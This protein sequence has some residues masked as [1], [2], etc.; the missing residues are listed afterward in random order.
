[1]KR[2]IVADEYMV[3]PMDD[4][5]YAIFRKQEDKK[6][7][8][9]RFVEGKGRLVWRYASTFGHA[10]LIIFEEMEREHHRTCDDQTITDVKAV[11]GVWERIEKRIME[12]E[13]VES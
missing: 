6:T 4:L 2:Y 13:V 11:R 9:R 8:C 7:G 3:E 1:M 10:M 5:N 12:M